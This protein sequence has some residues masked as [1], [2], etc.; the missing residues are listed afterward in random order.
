ML[1]DDEVLSIRRVEYDLDEEAK[2][3][4]AGGL[5]QADWVAKTLRNGSFAMP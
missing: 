3:L 1:I 4:A 5:P 2:A